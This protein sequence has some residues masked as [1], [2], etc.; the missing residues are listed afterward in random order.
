MSDRLDS[1]D[2]EA[3]LSRIQADTAPCNIVGLIKD[4]LARLDAL[5]GK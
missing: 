2:K 3:I 5:E 4:I 1:N